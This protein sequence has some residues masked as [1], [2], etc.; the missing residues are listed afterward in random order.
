[1]TPAEGASL[2]RRA[3]DL[4]I[5]FL[6]TAELYDNYETIRLSLRGLDQAIV[7]AT[8]SYAADEAGMRASL[9]KARRAM[10][11]EAIDL[12]LLHEVESAATLR[13]HRAALD[14][15]LDAKTRGL[16]RA[17]GVSTHTVA[18]VRAAYALPEVDVIHP[19]LNRR[20]LGVRDG[21]AAAM[22]G[23]VST[24]AEMGKGIY[25]MKVLAGGH[26]GSEAAEAFAYVAGV[27]GV[28]SMAVGMRSEE[29]V[30]VNLAYVHG[31][32]PPAAALAKIAGR[33]RRLFVEPWCTG[34]GTC[35]SACPFGALAV[36]D[37]RVAVME[38]R[39]LL[40]GYCAGSCEK[41]CLKVV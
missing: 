9:E 19:L 28:A 29:E 5:N 41:I 37:G 25:A 36:R 40:C 18:G 26:L 14:H 22:A 2:L 32:D 10:D 11:R 3:Y 1:M 33:P 24:A 20:G 17:V 15:L 8:K 23:A 38:D 39:C 30:L 16:V 21:D 13:G 6:D 27:P 31:F 35:L 12:F 4:G 7:V 34:C